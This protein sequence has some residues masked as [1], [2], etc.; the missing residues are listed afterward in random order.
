MAAKSKAKKTPKPRP[1]ARR[2]KQL[3]I[4]GT[5]QQFNPSVED[6]TATY[7]DVMMERCKMSKEED[8][9]KDNLINKMKE[10]GLDRYETAD[11]LVV[12]LT[13]KSNLRCKK[14]RDAESNGRELPIEEQ[15]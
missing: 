10:A 2:P 11:S 7:Y 14:K 9:A 13:A 4:P 8:E 12:T 15:P 6:A 5:E 3:V 1:R